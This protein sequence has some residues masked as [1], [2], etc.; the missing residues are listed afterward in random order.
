MKKQKIFEDG[1]KLKKPKS[2]H[3]FGVFA[4]SLMQTEKITETLE[5]ET[6]P[7]PSYH[8]I[9]L[10][11]AKEKLMNTSISA[12]AKNKAC[13][14]SDSQNLFQFLIEFFNELD[15]DKCGKLKGEKLL[16]SLVYLGVAS[17]PG[18]IG[19]TL[20]LIYKCDNIKKLRINSKNFIELFRN[21]HKTD[22]LLECLNLICVK[23]KPNVKTSR[24]LPEDK[25]KIDEVLMGFNKSMRSNISAS[26]Q[27]QVPPSGN[28]SSDALVTINEHI[29]LIK[30][31]WKV[32]DRTNK[33]QV[34]V[35]E[36]IAFL[37]AIGIAADKNEA[38]TLIFSQVIGKDTIVFDDFQQ[39]FAKSM[40]KGAL[41]NLSKRMA[42]GEYSNKEMSTGFRLQSYQRALIL[43]G[44]NCPNSE[45][46]EEE[47][48]KTIFAI[49]KYNPN[50]TER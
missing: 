21:D 33:N 5:R 20:C 41:L 46:S 1:K 14:N 3:F 24:V 8:P 48:A 29:E 49:K 47:G 12:W 28:N 25:G 2:D 40:L 45:I 19:R 43:S 7:M 22:K 17:D 42:V 13:S 34:K 31:W 36:L 50:K 9:N 23:L 16:E 35:V 15:E 10:A 32:L 39:I 30:S 37:I 27:L 11:S 18:V 38:K 4:P 44:S 26:M 6:Q